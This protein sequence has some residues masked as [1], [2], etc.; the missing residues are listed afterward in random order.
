LPPRFLGRV[1]GM[2]VMLF[3]YVDMLAGNY[4]VW[5][6]QESHTKSRAEIRSI[7]VAPS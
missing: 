3:K 6:I 5:R 4:R 1:T 7:D 2:R